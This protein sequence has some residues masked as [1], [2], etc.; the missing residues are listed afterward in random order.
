MYLC[1]LLSF[2]FLLDFFFFFFCPQKTTWILNYIHWLLQQCKLISL[3]EVE[4]FTHTQVHIIF[5]MRRKKNISWKE[6]SLLPIW[7]CTFWKQLAPQARKKK[8]TY[9]QC[10]GKTHFRWPGMRCTEDVLGNLNSAAYTPELNLY[11]LILWSH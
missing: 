7:N 6:I 11:V 10:N 9:Y 3:S 2:F 1:G 4:Q 5:S 8:S